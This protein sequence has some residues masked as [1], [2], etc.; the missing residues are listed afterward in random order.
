MSEIRQRERDLEGSVAV[1]RRPWSRR[2]FRRLSPPRSI[3][4]AGP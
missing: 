4:T 3:W 2:L 1:A